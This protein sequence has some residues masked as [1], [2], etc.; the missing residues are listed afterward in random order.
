MTRLVCGGNVVLDLIMKI[1]NLLLSPEGDNGIPDFNITLDHYNFIVNL[2][3]FWMA[4]DK[5]R[6]S[7]GVSTE[8]L[9]A[10]GVGLFITSTNVQY[11]R[12]V[13]LGYMLDV[14]I[15]IASRTE[16]SV[17]FKAEILRSTKKVGLANFTMNC[18]YLRNRRPAPLPSAI[19]DYPLG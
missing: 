16:T 18:V 19:A 5:W 2:K 7:I 6:E 3:L 1:E 17:T 13:R 9:V 8:S 14:E 15:E 11:L 12:E 4:V 10:E